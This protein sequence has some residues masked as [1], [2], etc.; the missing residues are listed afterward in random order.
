MKVDIDNY[1]RWSSAPNVGHSQAPGILQCQYFKGQAKHNDE[2]TNQMK[3][4][5]LLVTVSGR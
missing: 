2:Q 3:L 4:I 1:L 5:G